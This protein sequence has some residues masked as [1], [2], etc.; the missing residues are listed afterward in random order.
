MREA[1]G[2]T[3]KP[4]SN[5]A[6][7]STCAHERRS[8]RQPRHG[9]KRVSRLRRFS[10]DGVNGKRR[11]EEMSIQGTRKSIF[12]LVEKLGGASRCV[13]HETA[14]KLSAGF[15]YEFETRRTIYIGTQI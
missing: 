10:R 8:D 5:A 2:V 1:R 9:G 12:F 7:T 6:A 13:A 14:A 11:G 15:E 4:A 3:S